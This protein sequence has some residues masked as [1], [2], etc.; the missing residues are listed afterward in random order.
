MKSYSYVQE[1][2]NLRGWCYRIL[3]TRRW[4]GKVACRSQ[5]LDSSL[6][7]SPQILWETPD[8]PDEL[9]PPDA[10]SPRPAPENSL[11]IMGRR[12]VVECDESARRPFFAAGCLRC[13][14][15]P[16][17]APA[18]KLLKGLDAPDASSPFK[19]NQGPAG[20]QVGF[21]A[22]SAMGRAV[23]LVGGQ[24]SPCS[25]RASGVTD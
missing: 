5:T 15:T 24:R 18:E 23:I 8:E 7:R 1:V 19:V 4:L 25:A 14:Y 3:L 21:L 6:W 20:R 17:C 16:T 13:P 9:T 22:S 12:R 2:L 10:L 11:Q